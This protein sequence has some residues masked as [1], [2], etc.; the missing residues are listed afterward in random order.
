VSADV[1]LG[2]QDHYFPAGH[3]ER[4]RHCQADD[5]GP[6]HDALDLIHDSFF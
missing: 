2:L 5:T 3:G 6:D 1:I 4:P